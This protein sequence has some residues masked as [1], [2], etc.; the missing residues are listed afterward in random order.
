MSA[1]TLQLARGLQ[2]D[3]DY[4]GGGTFAWQQKFPRHPPRRTPLRCWPTPQRG[5]APRYNV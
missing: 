1:P 2:L 3:P 5:L 4:V